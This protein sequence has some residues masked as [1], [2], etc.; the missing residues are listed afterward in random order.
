MHHVDPVVAPDGT[1]RWPNGVCP[2]R[3][4]PKAD[5]FVALLRVLTRRS[6]HLEGRELCQDFASLAS[7]A[8]P[9]GEPAQCMANCRASI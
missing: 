2:L 3:S 4:R 5:Q 7:N 8:G 6:A 1:S 9:H